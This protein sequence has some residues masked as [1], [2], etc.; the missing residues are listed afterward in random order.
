MQNNVQL[1]HEEHE[2]SDTKFPLSIIA[3]DITDPLNVGS[4]FR[5][6]DALGIKKLYLCGRT[7]I[8]PN[9]KINKTARSAE[10]YVEYESHH[11]AETLV[12]ALKKS[13]VFIISLEITSSS[14]AINSEEFLKNIQDKEAICLIVGSENNGVSESLLSLSDITIGMGRLSNTN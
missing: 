3:N 6:C 12:T 1:T 14:I 11:G 13:G 4:L 5:L 8:P 7:P 10:K 9:T 2:K